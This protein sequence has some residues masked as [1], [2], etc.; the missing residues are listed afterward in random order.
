[1]KFLVP[2]YSCLQNHWLGGY[3]PQI[4]VLSI[5]CPL[6]S[7]EFVEPPPRTKFLG[8][9]LSSTTI[10]RETTVAFPWQVSVGLYCWQQHAGLLAQKQEGKNVLPFQ[11]NVLNI[12]VFNNS[13]AESESAECYIIPGYTWITWWGTVE[14]VSALLKASAYTNT[15]ITER[16]S[17]YTCPTWDSKQDPG[18]SALRQQTP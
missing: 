1:M 18:V 10:Q 12:H 16:K 14:W 2:N 15:K 7:T 9:P 13:G 6:S 3:W 5:L 4:P 8:K 11:V 17:G